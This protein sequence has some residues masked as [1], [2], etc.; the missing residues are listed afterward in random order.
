M[1]KEFTQRGFRVFGHI[2]YR[3]GG[4]IRVQ[5]SSLAFAGAHI[6]LYIEGDECKEHMGQHLMPTPHMSVKQTKELINALQSFVDEAEADEL[7]EPSEY[8]EHNDGI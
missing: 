7:A 1:E 4:A 5:E 8:L 3:N 6:W 2:Q